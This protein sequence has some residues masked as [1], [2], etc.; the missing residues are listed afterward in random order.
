MS[1]LR[2]V[3]R[4]ADRDR[5]RFSCRIPVLKDDLDQAENYLSEVPGL[6]LKGFPV[7]HLVSCLQAQARGF[8]AIFHKIVMCKP[9]NKRLVCKMPLS[10]L[11]ELG[12]WR[13]TNPRM[14]ARCHTPDAASMYVHTKPLKSIS[15]TLLAASS[16]PR[17]AL[18]LAACL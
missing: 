10:F 14:H 17:K 6:P 11:L 15:R 2:I 1:R 5:P 9:F 4:E 16:S 7:R 8:S 13:R 18:S 3:G 12:K